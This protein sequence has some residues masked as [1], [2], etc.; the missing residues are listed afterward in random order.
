VGPVSHLVSTIRVRALGGITF[1]AQQRPREGAV[2][3]CSRVLCATRAS[4]IAQHDGMPMP[5]AHSTPMPV[6]CTRA[7]DPSSCI[8][9]IS[10]FSS[11]DGCT[12]QGRAQGSGPRCEEGT[13]RPPSAVEPPKA[14]MRIPLSRGA[15]RGPLPPMASLARARA[16]G[17]PGHR[18][19]AVGALHVVALEPRRN[20]VSQHNP[21]TPRFTARRRATNATSTS[22]RRRSLQRFD[23]GHYAIA[24]HDREVGLSLA[25]I[26]ATAAGAPHR[27]PLPRCLATPSRCAPTA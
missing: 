24:K 23:P 11:P 18:H 6:A 27:H 7:M 19:H 14:R 3:C 17:H 12:R 5:A 9:V 22:A 1:K 26:Q 16:P 10:V 15:P 8:T 25:P 21:R 2:V 4:V 13:V 20:V